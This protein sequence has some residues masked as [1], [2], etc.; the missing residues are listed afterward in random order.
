MGKR[1]FLER[2]VGVQ[3]HLRRFDLFVTEQEGDH[4]GVVSTGVQQTHCG[5]VAQDVWRDRLRGQRR[6]ALGGKGRVLCDPA[7]E[8]FAGERPAGD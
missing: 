5:G 3:I 2:E 6:A 8:R 4:R 7:R 1:S